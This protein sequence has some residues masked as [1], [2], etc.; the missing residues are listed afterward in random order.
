M[1]QNWNPGLARVGICLATLLAV[2][3]HHQSPSDHIL[4]APDSST[5]CQLPVGHNSSISM[6]PAL[7]KQLGPKQEHSEA[8][9]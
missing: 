5:N 7:S 1:S 3:C 4:F 9:G 6:W 8:G 2:L